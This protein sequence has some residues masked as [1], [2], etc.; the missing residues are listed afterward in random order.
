M[1]KLP[2]INIISIDGVIRNDHIR[3]KSE[4]IGMLLDK[5]SFQRQYSFILCKPHGPNLHLTPLKT[6]IA[7]LSY[8]INETN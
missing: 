2:F 7:L 4:T 5:N 3:Y 8:I 6:S 1:T